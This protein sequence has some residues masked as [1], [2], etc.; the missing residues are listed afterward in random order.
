[1]TTIDNKQDVLDVRDIIERFKELESMFDDAM[2]DIPDNERGNKDNARWVKWE[3][4][5]EAE[6][7]KTLSEL[8]DELKGNGG[9]EQ[10]RGDWYPIALIR[11]SYFTDYI[12]DEL[13]DCGYIPK[14]LPSWIDINWE[15]TAENCKVDYSELEFDGVTYYY[16]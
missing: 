15:S 9:D 12:E 7:F 8:L 11:E 6:E 1:M 3:E 10:F 4:S 14:D 2:E 16:R 13:K 5:E